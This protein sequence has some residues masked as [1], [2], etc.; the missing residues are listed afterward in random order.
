MKKTRVDYKKSD[1]Y[2][3]YS[4]FHGKKELTRGQYGIIIEKLNLKIVDYVLEGNTFKFPF[5]LGTLRIV[6]NKPK[7]VFNEDGTID[8]IKS[9]I[10]INWKDTN[11]LWEKYPKLRRKQ[12]IYYENEDTDGYI[13]KI[14]WSVFGIG[15]KSRNIRY[16][17]FKPVRFFQRTLKKYIIENNKIDYEDRKL[18]TVRSD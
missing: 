2:S 7:Y 4:V 13:F 14:V 17:K 1:F 15:K 3:Y 11:A 12:Y 10:S 8:N 5:R 6:R 18:H 9:K 16:Y